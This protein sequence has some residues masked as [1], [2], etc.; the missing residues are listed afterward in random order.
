MTTL[1]FAPTNLTNG[2]LDLVFLV[3]V[4]GAPLALKWW[5]AHQAAIVKYYEKHTSA[6]ER[7]IL[8]TLAKD[9]VAWTERFASSPQGAQKFHQATALVQGWLKARG[10]TIS[11][12]EVSAAIQT[13]YSELKSSGVLAASGPTLAP[14]P[15]PV[16]K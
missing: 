11:L 15:A 8:A 12:A 5:N 6:E 3:I 2:L 10:I 4:I 16:A 1:P 9:A 14:A 7:A 13:A